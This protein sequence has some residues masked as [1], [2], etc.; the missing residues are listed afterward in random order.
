MFFSKRSARFPGI[1][2]VTIIIFTTVVHVS[3]RNTA[4]ILND[5]AVTKILP[6]NARNGKEDDSIQR[7]KDLMSFDEVEIFPL[8]EKLTQDD[9][10]KEIKLKTFTD[11]YLFVKGKPKDYKFKEEEMCK[12]IE[13]SGTFKVS[14]QRYLNADY[15][16][17]KKALENNPTYAKLIADAHKKFKPTIPEEKQWFRFAGSSTWLPQYDCHYMVSRI[18]YSPSGIP[19]KAFASFLYIQLFD[20]DWNEI[21]ERT[22][23]LPYEQKIVHNV[24]DSDGTIR[25]VVLETL[26]AFR[27][28]TYPGFLPITFESELEVP[29]GK[30]YWGPEDPRILTRKNP[31]GFDEPVIVFNMKRIDIRKRVMHMYLPF[32]NK[33]T[34]LRRRTEKFAYIEKNWTPFIS[35]QENAHLQNGVIEKMNFIYSIDPLEI[36][37]CEIATGLC[38]FLQRPMKT[39]FNYVGAL[40]GGSQLVELPISDLIPQHVKDK[41][42]FP[43]NRSIYIG[44]ARAHLNKCGCGE[45]MYRP[46]MVTLVEDYD[47]INKK[48]FYKLSDVSQYFDFNAFVPPWTQPKLDKSGQLIEDAT[49]PKQCEGRNVLIPNSIAYWKIDSILKG[50]T[51]YQRKYFN[52]I[53]TD[54]Q[55]ADQ[56]AALVM[57]HKPG[58]RRSLEKR[59]DHNRII[60]ND[61][62][63]VTLSAADSDVSI[64]HVKGLFDYL[65]KLP[66]L[67]DAKTVISDEYSFQPAGFDLNNRCAMTASGEYCAKYGERMQK[68]NDEQH[69]LTGEFQ[70]E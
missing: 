62:M 58:Q 52:H 15:T 16:A 8:S 22:L 38:D 53:P 26:I 6:D 46:N 21:P 49:P 25:E 57:K 14:K 24:I 3:R 70:E 34:I 23:S 67:F 65:L 43:E 44:W 17:Y 29:S 56:N 30:Y 19:N 41:L 45:S 18:M 13:Y 10:F 1:V 47:P 59:A 28:V 7:L 36:L 55:S 20:R 27:E 60:F 11:P 35:R 48:Y 33:V 61:Y 64:V 51:L 39:D 5:N 2:F 4:A 66:A 69:A 32:S 9:N 68:Y 31:L 50:N 40:R 63:G 37:S 54:E 12:R 42:K